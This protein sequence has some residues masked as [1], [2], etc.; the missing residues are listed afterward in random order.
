MVVA[1]YWDD[2]E[3]S[4]ASF[5]GGFWRSG[6]LGR[7]DADG[8]VQI[9]D[10]RKD[11]LNRGGY[12]IYSVEVE[13]V[14]AAVPGVIEAAVV[15]RP[16]PVLGE[17]VHAVVRVDA[18]LAATPER[19]RNRLSD[20]AGRMLAD[21]KVPETWSIVDAPLPRNANG[22][23]MK[24]ALRPTAAPGTTKSP[25]RAGSRRSSPTATKGRRRLPGRAASP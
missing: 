22:K 11:M 16:C 25:P 10:R 14:L 17:R 8:F 21:Y 6:D 12:K 3:A 24:R 5:V 7:V 15:G 19:A 18:A 23:L 13:N 2:T 4:A 1:G 9:L 20:Y